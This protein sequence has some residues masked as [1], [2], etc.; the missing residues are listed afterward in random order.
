MACYYFKIVLL[1]AFPDL[2]FIVVLLQSLLCIKGALN[3]VEWGSL[4]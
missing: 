4:I 3:T 2:F 1:C